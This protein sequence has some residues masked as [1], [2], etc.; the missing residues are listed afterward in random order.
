MDSWTVE[1][2]CNGL[3]SVLESEG[4]LRFRHQSFVDFILNK[5]M[6]YPPLHITTSDCHHVLAGQCLRVMKEKLRFNICEISSSFLLNSEVLESLPSLE[7]YIPSHLQYASRYWVHHLHDGPPSGDSLSL[8]RDFLRIRF[9]FWLEVA[10]LCGFVDD[11]P[12]MLI[13]LVAWLQVISMR[14]RRPSL[15]AT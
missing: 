11:V 15:T 9:L 4:G 13:P 3:R 7:A 14:R 2:I 6:A 10:S 12:S 5:E 8:V 1:H